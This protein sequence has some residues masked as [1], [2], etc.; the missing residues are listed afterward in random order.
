[1]RAPLRLIAGLAALS[2]LAAARAGEDRH[3]WSIA[4]DLDALSADAGPKLGAAPDADFARVAFVYDG[5][6]RPTLN[7]H[8]VVDA[9]DDGPAGPGITEAYLSWQ[10][11]PRSPF[12]HTLRAGVFYP[13]LSLE[14]TAPGWTSPFAGSF[15]AIDTWVGEELKTIG[16]EWR[17]SRAIGPRAAGRELGLIAAAYYGNDPAGALLSWRGF[18]VHS[19]QSRLGDGLVLPAVPQIQPG[20]MFATQ[21]PATKPF[22]E[23]DQAPGFYYGAEWRLGDRVRLAALA[24]DNH[25]DPLTVQDGQYGWHT[26]FDHLGAELA[27]PARLGLVVQRLDGTTAM[28]PVMNGAH[29]VDNAFTSYSALL[30]RRQ[31]AHRWTLRYDDFEIRDRDTTPLDDNGESGHAVTAAY[32]YEPDASWSLGLEW[33]ALTVSRPAFAYFNDPVEERERLFRLELRYRVG[34]GPAQRD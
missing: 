1:M 26:V 17:V 20:M 32:R 25:A 2:A 31:D 23:T 6:I 3:S 28:G 29:V 24:Y 22:V 10:P 14:N 12:R 5:R 4:L 7:I 16:T 30:T 9:V 15:S 21:A 13:P 27:L 33:V 34:P 18:A 11:V 8:A 19:R